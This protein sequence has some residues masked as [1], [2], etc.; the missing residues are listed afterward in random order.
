MNTEERADEATIAKYADME[1]RGQKKVIGLLR[2]KK[3][4]W[5]ESRCSSCNILLGYHNAQWETTYLCD[6]C[7][8]KGDGL[9]TKK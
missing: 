5:V 7:F 2:D 8:A 1:K 6:K 9:D 3:P 4:A